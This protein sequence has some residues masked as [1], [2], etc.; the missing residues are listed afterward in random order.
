MVTYIEISQALDELIEDLQ[1]STGL[2]GAA[3]DPFDLA[4]SLR[5]SV[6]VDRIPPS[7]FIGELGHRD[8]VSILKQQRRW[9][10]KS[11]R[12]LID[13]FNSYLKLKLQERGKTIITRTLVEGRR[14]FE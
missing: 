4:E 5:N 2:H 1:L 12:T 14:V 11:E 8:V 13:D 6:L 10:S 9:F 3:I 7:P